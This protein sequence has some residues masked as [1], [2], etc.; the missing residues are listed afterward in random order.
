MKKHLSV[1]ALAVRGTLYKVLAICAAAALLQLGLCV[2]FLKW[3]TAWEG[4]PTLLEQLI[5]LTFYGVVAKIAFIAVCAMLCVFSCDHSPSRSGYT[6]RRLQIGERTA[7]FWFAVCNAGMLALFWA[8]QLAT[9]LAVYL[10]CRWADPSVAAFPQ[11]L[12]IAFYRNGYLHA[13][14][15]LREVSLWVRNLSLLAA[16]ALCCAAFSYHQ[17]RGHN[18]LEPLVL[19]LFTLFYFSQPAG[20]LDSDL[21]LILVALAAGV[22]SLFSLRGGAT[23]DASS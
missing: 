22:F 21:V 11:T 20:S 23:D 6:L 12:L 2:F 5:D 9:A 13:L 14:L 15:P 19:M 3:G 1:F 4:I 7:V 8:S 16:L 18:R 10:L 17:R